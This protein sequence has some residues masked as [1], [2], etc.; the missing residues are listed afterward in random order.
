MHERTNDVDSLRRLAGLLRQAI[1]NVNG[2]ASSS[3]KPTAQ[4]KR[5]RSAPPIVAPEP[6]SDGP[7]LGMAKI[8]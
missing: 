3:K 5:K 4:I 8:R 6:R 1:T 7:G 2:S